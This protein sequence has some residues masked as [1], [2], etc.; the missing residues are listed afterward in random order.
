MK[1]IKN[2]LCVMIVMFALGSTA[3]AVEVSVGGSA[4]FGVP[5]FRGKDAKD[6][7]SMLENMSGSPYPF[8]SFSIPARL[9]LMIEVLPFLA[10]ETGV[11][12]ENTGMMYNLSLGLLK[13]STFV[14]N[15]SQVYIPVML[16]GQYEYK[17]GVTYLSV[18]VKLGIPL[19]EDYLSGFDGVLSGSA[20]TYTIKTSDFSMDVSFAIG[21]EFRLGDANYL[22]IR[23]GYDLNVIQ[24]FDTKDLKDAGLEAY[25]SHFMDDIEFALTYRY[26]FGSKWK[27]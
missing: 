6:F 17:I 25:E 12:Y 22:G 1:K 8:M 18:G 7:T 13:S 27:K 4:G 9:D 23:I 15:K 24:N 2:L 10:I 26:A 20:N 21:Q 19:G 3:E 11:G 14:I 5:F 16:R